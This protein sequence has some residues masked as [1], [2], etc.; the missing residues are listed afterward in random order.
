MSSIG[1]PAA[2]A[3]GAARG[4]TASAAP[5]RATTASPARNAPAISWPDTQAEGN[6]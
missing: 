6:S 1:R 2:A 3:S 5:A 4:S